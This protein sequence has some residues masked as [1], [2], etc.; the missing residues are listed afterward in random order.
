MISNVLLKIVGE[1]QKMVNLRKAAIRLQKANTH[2]EVNNK[3][4]RISPSNDSSHDY[5]QNCP[6]SN[7]DSSE[8]SCFYNSLCFGNRLRKRRRLQFAGATRDK[9]NETGR[10]NTSYG[11]RSLV[12]REFSSTNQK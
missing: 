5:R 9:D 6:D 2:K 10:N 12:T 4:L 3:R 7:I 8:T 1:K 11:G